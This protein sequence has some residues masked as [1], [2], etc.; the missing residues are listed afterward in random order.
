MDK[1]I[2]VYTIIFIVLYINN[3][4]QILPTKWIDLIFNIELFILICYFKNKFKMNK[5]KNNK[6]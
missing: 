1:C 4:F 2:I 3:I 6:G 5:F